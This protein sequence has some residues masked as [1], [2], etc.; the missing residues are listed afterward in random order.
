MGIGLDPL[1]LTL[2][3]MALTAVVL[4]LTVIPFLVLMNDARYVGEHV[5]GRVANL[6][7][8]GIVVLAA[9]LAVVGIP[10]EIL[11]SR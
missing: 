10:L 1:K 9:I 5:N 2:F 11:G 3:S 6:V 7:V 8:A 4:P